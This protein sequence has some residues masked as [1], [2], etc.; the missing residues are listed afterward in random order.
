MALFLFLVYAG[1]DWR[2]WS[3]AWDRMLLEEQNYEANKEL[4]SKAS[5][6]AAA[7]MIKI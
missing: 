1:G 7:E 5:R 4:H 2:I 3:S 6:S